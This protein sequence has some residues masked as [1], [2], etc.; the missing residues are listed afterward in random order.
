MNWDY[1][2]GF[3]DGEG[4]ITFVKN[5]KTSFR[6]PWLSFTNNELN[7]LVEIQDFISKELQIKGFISKKIK[8]SF[9]N[10]QLVYSNLPKVLSIIKNIDTIHI[11]KR[12][13]INMIINELP[14]ITIRNGKYSKEILNKRIE[15][16]DRFF[17]I[18][19]KAYIKQI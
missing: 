6:T 17:S 18:H 4:C 19:S 10:Y 7:I 16:E 9:I 3:F 15:F 2:T 14:Q 12:D 1:I 8:G 13:R 11:K 5:T